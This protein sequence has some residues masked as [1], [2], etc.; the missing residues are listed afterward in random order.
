LISFRGTNSV[1]D[2]KFDLDA[3]LI[4]LDDSHQDIMVHA[5]FRHKLKSIEKQIRAILEEYNESYDKVIFTG[6]SLGGALATLAAPLFGEAYPTKS[7]ECL[8]FG[9][10]RVGDA[11]FV[12]WFNAKVDSNFRVINEGDRVVAL[13]IQKS[14]LHV[15]DAI[16]FSRSG[17]VAQVSDVPPGRRLWRALENF[18]L[19]SSLREHHLDTYQERLKAYIADPD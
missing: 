2:I 8:T 11:K 1:V 5:G 17:R 6:H 3:R 10:P 16:S 9:T 14:F 13:P 7:I 15:S 4:K 18:D 19:E 12:E